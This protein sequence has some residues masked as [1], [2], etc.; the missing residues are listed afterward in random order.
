[1]DGRNDCLLQKGKSVNV[2]F[3]YIGFILAS[4]FIGVGTN[5]YVGFGSFV[6]AF[7]MIHLVGDVRHN[8]IQQLVKVNNNLVSD[9]PQPA[10]IKG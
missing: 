3:Y 4:I 5:I 9:K 10:H 6:M 8:I 2:T 7:T 1:M